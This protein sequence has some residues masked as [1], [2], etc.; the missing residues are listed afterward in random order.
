M[1]GVLVSLR[2]SGRGTGRPMRGTPTR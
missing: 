2:T 1:W